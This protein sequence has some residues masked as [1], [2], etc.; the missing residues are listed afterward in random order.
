MPGALVSIVA[1]SVPMPEIALVCGGDGRFELRLPAGRFTFQAHGATRTGQV[2]V[3][4][5]PANDEILIVM[6]S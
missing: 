2:E 5:A 6:E 4:G 3:E 1:S